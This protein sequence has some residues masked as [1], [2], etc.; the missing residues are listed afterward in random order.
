[1]SHKFGIFEVSVFVDSEDEV[2][3]ALVAAVR[4]LKDEVWESMWRDEVELPGLDA[5]V[6]RTAE[7]LWKV[8]VIWNCR[9]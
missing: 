7:G 9:G 1:M 5:D 8:K 3:E 6:E 4:S 2:D